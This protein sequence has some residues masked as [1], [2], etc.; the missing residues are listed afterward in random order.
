[1]LCETFLTDQTHQFIN[2]PG[3]TLISNECVNRRGGGTGILV[4]E[5]ILYKVKEDLCPFE[6]GEIEATFIE[7]IAKNRKPIVVGSL[8]KPQNSHPKAFTSSL[9]ET[10][11]KIQTE[12]KELILGMD[13]NMDLIKS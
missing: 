6:E 10:I 11:A 13:H 4:R 7:I 8:Y 12:C 5:E 1:M 2:L 3:Y 9:N